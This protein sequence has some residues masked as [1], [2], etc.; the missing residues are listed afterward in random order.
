MSGFNGQWDINEKLADGKSFYSTWR[1]SVTQFTVAGT[2]FDMSMSPGNPSPQYYAST[3]L[4][5]QQM[6]HSTDGGIRHGTNVSPSG[7]YLQSFTILSSSANGLPMPFILLDYL[8]YYPFVDTGT[9]DQQNMINTS[10]LPRY[11]DG[12][13]VQMMAV[14]VAASSS[15]T[16]PTFRVSYTNEKGISGRLSPVC[17]L[18]TATFNGAIMSNDQASASSHMPFIPLQSGDRGVRS[19]ESLTF[20]SGTDVGLLTLVLVKP[21][22]T[23]VLLEQ[24]APTEVVPLPH[25][26]NLPRIYD[27]AFLG[28]LVNPQGSLVGVAFHGEIQTMWT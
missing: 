24:T 10:S 18:H 6:R 8:L 16:R 4:V 9:N 1:K 5:V 2:W 25:Q 20:I 26:S 15:G 22:I 14:S 19:I 21:L 12:V 3:P 23:S 17:T 27:D 13:G 11:T 7:K 28:L